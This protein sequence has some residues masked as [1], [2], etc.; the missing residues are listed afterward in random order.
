[1]I[2][3]WPG[4]GVDNLAGPRI[5]NLELY[6]RSLALASFFYLKELLE[7]EAE[8]LSYNITG[9]TFNGGIERHDRGV[10]ETPGCLDLVFCIAQ[11]ALKL[12]KIR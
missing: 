9:E 3:P 12:Q 8:N 4:Q 11:F 7:L 5:H 1:M 2:H 6:L 10:V